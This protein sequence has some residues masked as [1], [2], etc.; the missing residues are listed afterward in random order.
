ME[1]SNKIR[2]GIALSGGGARGIAH[3]GVLAAL[4]NYGI[5]PQ[6]VSGT[7]MGAIIGLLYA[8]GK[9]PKEILEIIKRYKFASIMGL[10]IARTGFIKTKRIESF[11]DENVVAKTFEE[12]KLEYHV[13]ATNLN[14]GAYRIF[15]TGE[16]KRP[17]LASASIPVLFQPVD[18][19]GDLYVDGGLLNNLPIEPIK[20]S[21]D[22]I[23][24]VHVNRNGRKDDIKSMKSVGDRCFR[25]AIWQTV[26]ERLKECDFVIEPIKVYDFSTFSFDK[27]DQL[28]EHGYNSTEKS[29]LQLFEQFDLDKIYQKSNEMNGIRTYK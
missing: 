12:L 23:I 10:N 21:C 1:L 6:A 18:I 26:R 16:L 20:K 17:V 27:A 28:F 22:K 8:D 29:I 14:E 2:L 19:D 3:I 24:G 5:Y 15:N 9:K 7:S 25:I 11:I 13:S 4:E